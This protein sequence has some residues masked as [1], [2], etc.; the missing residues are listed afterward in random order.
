MTCEIEGLGEFR[1]IGSPHTYPS[2]RAILLPGQPNPTGPRS[3][4]HTIEVT[5]QHRNDETN[6]I[7]WGGQSD[8]YTDFPRNFMTPSTLNRRAETAKRSEF[9]G[10]LPAR[11]WN[12]RKCWNMGRIDRRMAEVVTVERFRVAR[13]RY[14]V[15][16]AWTASKATWGRSTGPMPATIRTDR[17][18]KNSIEPP[19]G[20]LFEPWFFP[21]IPDVSRRL[22]SDRID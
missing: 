11:P 21:D 16:M 14:S 9:N 10:F 18:S 17:F 5:P 22:L 6:P 20:I 19:P 15:P 2:K 3:L 4:F 13:V 1:G 12:V 7:F 8:K